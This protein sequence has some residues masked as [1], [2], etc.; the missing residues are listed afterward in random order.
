M[1]PLFRTEEHIG[2]LIKKAARL[3]EQIANKGLEELD[4]TYAQTI[5]LIRLW[6]KD[7]MSQ[8]ELTKSSGLKQPTVVRFLDRM[9]RD[10][11]LKRVRNEHDRRIFNFFL[12]AKA[13]KACKKLAGHASTMNKISTKHIVKKDIEKLCR[14]VSS[15]IKNLEQFLEDSKIF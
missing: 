6:E 14:L 8:I 11:L 4:V 2:I 1:N 3:F 13:Q 7:G 12:T 9:E 10:G 15:V 5:F